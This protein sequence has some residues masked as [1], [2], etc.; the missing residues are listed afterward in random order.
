MHVDHLRTIAQRRKEG[1]KKAASTRKAKKAKK[2]VSEYYYS[3][4]YYCNPF[5]PDQL[6]ISTSVS[7]QLFNNDIVWRIFHLYNVFAHTKALTFS[8]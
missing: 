6:Q 4:V 5:T 1:A 7:F 8:S 2:A 3:T